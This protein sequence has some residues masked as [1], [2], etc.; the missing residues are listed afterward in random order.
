MTSLASKQ[1]GV[2]SIELSIIL[3][4]FALLIVF[5]MDV[6][7]KQSVKGKL[8]RLSYSLVSLLKERTQLFDGSATLSRNEVNAA[9]SLAQYSLRS[10]MGSFD[11]SRLGLMIEQQQFNS[12]QAPTPAINGLHVF[13]AG[14]Y[15]CEPSERLSTKT[16]LSPITNFGNRLALY[17]VTLCYKTNN[18]FGS[19]VGKQW[20]LTS[21][22]SFS[23]GR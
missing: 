13:R 23:I 12:E 18:L 3:I 4:G 21:S 11:A 5:T 8:D 1:R 22:T 6:V 2:F 9:L 19:L 14:E 20:E 7:T 17:Q 10:T 16:D 15:A